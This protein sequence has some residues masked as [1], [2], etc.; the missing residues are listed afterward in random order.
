M[1]EISFS[2]N[3]KEVSVKSPTLST[4]LK[5]WAL[6]ELLVVLYLSNRALWSLP[7]RKMAIGLIVGWVITTTVIDLCL[8]LQSLYLMG[9]DWHNSN[10]LGDYVLAGMFVASI[11]FLT[12]LLTGQVHGYS[13]DNFLFRKS[14]YVLVVF[15]QQF[16]LQS[17]IFVRLEK[18][19]VRSAVMLATLFFT[20]VHWP[21]PWLTVLAFLGGS[22]SCMIFQRNRN[23]FSIALA[24]GIIGAAIAA[25]WRI[26]MR[27]GA[28]Y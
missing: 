8:K 2:Y 20:W 17:Y 25:F 21:N 3:N 28:G 19:S 13:V 23:L 18:L 12:G 24:H 10:N 15:V 6:A 5:V 7:E 26:I 1:A 4:M 22:I 14:G 16:V 9:L 27:V 11:I